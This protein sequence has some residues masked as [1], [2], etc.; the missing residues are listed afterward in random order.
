MYKQYILCKC[1]LIHF[2][3]SDC[4]HE[5]VCATLLHAHPVCVLHCWV[6]SAPPW[7]CPALLGGLSTATAHPGRVLHCW[8]AATAHPRRV[9]HCW[10]ASAL[11]LPTLDVSCMGGLSTATAHP[12][13]VLHCWVDSALRLPTLDVSCIAGWT[14]HCD[15]PPWT[16]P[17]LLGGLSTATAH[18]GRVL[19]GWPQHCDCPPWTCPALL[20][21]LSTATA[22]PGRVLHGWPQHCN[23][24]PWTCP[25]HSKRLSVL[26]LISR[27]GWMD[28]MKGMCRTLLPVCMTIFAPSPVSTHGVCILCISTFNHVSCSPP[29]LPGQFL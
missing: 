24:P 3:N 22:H 13:R 6:A 19:H 25:E 1:N 15:C 27:A 11:R 14:Q 20:G 18:P 2:G 16:W 28:H 4:V 10:V 29:E 26:V 12:G 8:V 21:G 5:Q 9:L 7:T 23:C 17:A